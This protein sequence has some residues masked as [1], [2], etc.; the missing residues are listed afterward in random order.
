M[1]TCKY[2]PVRLALC[3]LFCWTAFIPLAAQDR[4]ENPEISN[5]R[6]QPRKKLI[7][8]GTDE[9]NT[10]FLRKHLREMEQLPF[11]GLVLHL[12]GTPH[13]NFAWEVWGPRRYEL[14][15]FRGCVEDLLASKSDKLT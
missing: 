5:H 11:D 9:P 12:N 15:E 2:N 6:S 13:G 7:E 4:G 1:N 14:E 3:G 8:W 10:Q